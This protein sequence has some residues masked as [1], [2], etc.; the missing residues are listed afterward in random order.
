MSWKWSELRCNIDPYLM[1]VVAVG[2]NIAAAV[3]ISMKYGNGGEAIEQIYDIY[4]GGS[5]A[6]LANLAEEPVDLVA[7]RSRQDDVAEQLVIDAE[8]HRVGEHAD[9]TCHG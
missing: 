3:G 7:A 6:V 8:L 9:R 4:F 1:F 2:G 5:D